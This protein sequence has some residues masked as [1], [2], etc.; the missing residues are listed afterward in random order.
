MRIGAG[1]NKTLDQDRGLFVLLMG[2]IGL[3]GDRVTVQYFDQC[4]LL[5]QR[6]QV[7]LRIRGQVIVPPG[8][9]SDRVQWL[10]YSARDL[11]ALRQ[12]PQYGVLYRG[13]FCI[14]NKAAECLTPKNEPKTNQFFIRTGLYLF[15]LEYLRGMKFS[16]GQIQ[17]PV[18]GDHRS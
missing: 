12:V 13:L 10:V 1:D 14:I 2:G 4:P 7:V 17:R 15:Q 8:P 3:G 18:Q 16:L 5:L 9:G 6:P 11:P